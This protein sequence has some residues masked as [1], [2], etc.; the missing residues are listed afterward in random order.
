MEA[1]I[2]SHEFFLSLPALPLIFVVMGR[3]ERIKDILCGIGKKHHGWKDRAKVQNLRSRSF[4]TGRKCTITITPEHTPKMR[5]SN[6]PRDSVRPPKLQVPKEV[7]GR[8]PRAG[9]PAGCWRLRSGR[10]FRPGWH[11]WQLWGGRCGLAWCAGEIGYGYRAQSNGAGPLSYWS[12]YQPR[13][14]GTFSE[15][16]QKG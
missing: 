13:F 6:K 12:I 2:R 4:I 10:A 15:S 5:N 7:L 3:E 14:L 9:Y 11:E 8:A 16:A 1:E